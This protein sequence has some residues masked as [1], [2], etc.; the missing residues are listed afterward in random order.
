MGAVPKGPDT[1]ARF[2]PEDGLGHHACWQSPPSELP[3]RKAQGLVLLE[4]GCPFSQL[5]DVPGSWPGYTGSPLGISGAPLARTRRGRWLCTLP[6]LSW[7]PWGLGLCHG[8][9]NQSISCYGGQ[10]PPK[11]HVSKTHVCKVKT[12]LKKKKSKKKATEIILNICI[13]QPQPLVC[14]SPRSDGLGSTPSSAMDMLWDL[15][16]TAPPLSV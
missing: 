5:W 15:G 9:G 6:C 3:L 2:G 16:Q 13:I 7:R 4:R 14:P 11:S 1:P 12:S 10:S 8:R